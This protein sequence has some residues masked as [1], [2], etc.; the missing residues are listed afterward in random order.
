M[1]SMVAD[2]GASDNLIYSARGGGT[3]HIAIMWVQVVPWEGDTCRGHDGQEIL[4]GE[5]SR[6]LVIVDGSE[7]GVV[8]ADLSL[9]PGVAAH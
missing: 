7:K 6:D 1:C 4:L 9:V 3:P 2:S 8:V 5:L